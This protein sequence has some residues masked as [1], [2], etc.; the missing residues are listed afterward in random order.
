[1]IIHSASP[2]NL[3][4]PKLLLS[5]QLFYISKALL[6]FFLFNFTSGLLIVKVN[7]QSD[8][9][10]ILLFVSISASICLNTFSF[11]FG[12]RAENYQEFDFFVMKHKPYYTMLGENSSLH[13]CFQWSTCTDLPGIVCYHWPERNI[14]TF[15]GL[16]DDDAG[17]IL[18]FYPT[19]TLS[20]HAL[21][22]DH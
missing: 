7:S 12:Q 3:S 10:K 4:A 16:S 22:N 19:S 20:R 13:C 6:L 2:L 17:M 18:L 1:M 8:A 21:K 5:G 15:L 14:K 9:S 11:V